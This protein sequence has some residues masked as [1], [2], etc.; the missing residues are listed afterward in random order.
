MLYIAQNQQIA[1]ETDRIMLPR[2]ILLFK[3]QSIVVLQV[4]LVSGVQQSDSVF[5]FRFFSLI[6]Y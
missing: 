5:F 6:G 1:E 4:V 3:N 2:G